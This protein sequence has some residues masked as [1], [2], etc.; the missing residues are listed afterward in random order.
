MK[1]MLWYNNAHQFAS[2]TEDHIFHY[3]LFLPCNTKMASEII[4]LLHDKNAHIV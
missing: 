3:S 1:V 4:T 2:D